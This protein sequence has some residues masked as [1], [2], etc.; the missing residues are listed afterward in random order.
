MESLEWVRQAAALPPGWFYLALVLSGVV[1]NLVP[2]LPG[3]M[4]TVAGGYL[5]ARGTV[6]WPLAFLASAAGNW[7]GFLLVFGAGRWLG[8]SRLHAM[9]QGWF[10]H[11]ELERAEGW[12]ARWGY[13]IILVNRFLA[14][15]R[16]VVSLFAGVAELPWRPVA[17]LSLVSSLAW[18][19]LLTLLGMQIQERWEDLLP[20]LD[21]YNR[22][23]VAL[24][25]LA[26]LGGWGW[27][28]WRKRQSPG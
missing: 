12:F 5:A 20:L 19:G 11:R 18:T 25:T 21:A 8:H 4:A 16:A 2:M 17:V 10:P 13:G 27:L 15:T 23:M 6:T 28:A 22:L 7:F 24:V 1:E 14:G 3:D 9:L 26:L